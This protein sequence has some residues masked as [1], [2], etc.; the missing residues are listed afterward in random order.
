MAVGW[1]ISALPGLRRSL[2]GRPYRSD[3][4]LPLSHPPKPILAFSK[5][6]PGALRF[7]L[8]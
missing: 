5:A 2:K 6:Q 8:R 7:H 3:G 4:V 1:S